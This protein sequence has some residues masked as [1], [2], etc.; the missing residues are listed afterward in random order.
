MDEDRFNM[1]MCQ[2]LKVVGVNSQGEIERI[3][4]GQA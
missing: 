1:A 2:F 4:K 3:A